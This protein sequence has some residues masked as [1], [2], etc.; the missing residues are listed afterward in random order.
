[1]KIVKQ[2]YSMFFIIRVNIFGHLK[3][4][5]SEIQLPQL[6]GL[7]IKKKN[8]VLGMENSEQD[9][10]SILIAKLLA[11]NENNDIVQIQVN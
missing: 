5:G 11:E 6:Y 3:F 4:H 9:F 1:M 8:Y 7:S 10:H 2:Y